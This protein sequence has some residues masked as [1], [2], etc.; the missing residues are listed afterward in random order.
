M[1]VAQLRQRQRGRLGRVGCGDRGWAYRSANFPTTPGA[2]DTSHNGGLDVF[3][4]RVNATGNGLLYSTYL[5][6][7]NSDGASAVAVD[8][9]GAVTV[10]GSTDSTNF[11]TTPGAYDTSHNGGYDVFVARL[12]PAAAGLLYSTYLGGSEDDYC[13][14]GVVDASGAATVAGE[15]VSANFPTTSGA[16]DRASTVANLMARMHLWRG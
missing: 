8:A 4:A 6:G 7:G 15:T 10:A 2:Y 16:Y 14:A 5:G 3:V 13:Y 11:P 1:V 12:T 9:S